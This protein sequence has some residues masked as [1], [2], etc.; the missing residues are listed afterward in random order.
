MGTSAGAYRRAFQ[1]TM[2][3]QGKGTGCRGKKNIHTHELCK[4]CGDRSFHKQKQR[5]A[6][7]GYPAATMR[8]YG[9]AYKSKRQGRKVQ[10]CGKMTHMT[11]MAKHRAYVAL[12]GKAP[13]RE[14]PAHP[15]M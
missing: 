7:C 11:K 15:G 8:S 3:K 1:L 9:W 12:H 5:C 2:G 6:G 14:L 13:S 10:G 4:R